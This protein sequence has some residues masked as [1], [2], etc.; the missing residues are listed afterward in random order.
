MIPEYEPGKVQTV[1]LHDGSR[2]SLKKL[3]PGEHDPTD[4]M[5]ALRLIEEARQNEQFI[6]GLIYVDENRQTLAETSHMI[7]EP[8]VHLSNEVIR[9]PREALDSIMNQLICCD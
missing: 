7:D 3:D 9:P 2:V 5:A 1:D 8:L 4:R 6:T